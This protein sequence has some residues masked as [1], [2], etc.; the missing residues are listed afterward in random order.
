MHRTLRT[1]LAA[2]LVAVITL[3]AISITQD[4]G[5]SARIDCTAE[6]LYTLSDG[7]KAI[8]A[9][10]DR[11]IT[12][13]LYY[14]ATAAGKGPDWMK[15]LS[16][17]FH[18]VRD[19]LGEYEACA[20]GKIKLEV[21]DP[22]PYSD[23]EDQAIRHGLP[24]FPVNKDEAFYF[25]LVVRASFGKTETIPV[26]RGR[27]E[28]L[29]E[30]EITS[31]IEAAITRKRPRVGLLST[32]PVLGD[33]VTPQ[34]AQIMR[35]TQGRGPRLPWQFV[36]DLSRKYDVVEIAGDA[37]T[38]EENIDLLL[39]I[40]PKDLPE[41]TLFAIDQFVLGG[42]RMVACIDPLCFA[43]RPVRQPGTMTPPAH[44]PVSDLN[45]LL[46][47]WGV[48][49]ADK[50]V[51]GDRNLGLLVP[52]PGVSPQRY[53]R[54]VT[55]ME[56]GN[57]CMGPGSPISAGLSVMVLDCS[58][59]IEA[60]DLPNVETVPLIQTTDQGGTVAV[61][62][63]RMMRNAN[64]L[65]VS[66]VPADKPV[67]MGYLVKGRFR[68]AYP[69]GID[70][71]TLPSDGDPAGDGAPAGQPTMRKLTGL[72]VAETD[73]M[74]VV[75]ADV[76]FLT[77]RYY[78]FETTDGRARRN[79]TILFNAL[80][81]LGGSD[82][83]ISIRTRGR[84]RRSFTL[85]DKMEQ[86]ENNETRTERIHCEDQIAKIEKQHQEALASGNA[87][88]GALRTAAQLRAAAELKQQ[89]RALRQKIRLVRR[90]RQER[91]ESLGKRLQAINT[92]LV[93][94]CVLLLAI[95]LAVYHVLARRRFVGQLSRRPRG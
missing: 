68:S 75:L 50:S 19:L 85:V 80:D 48:S 90:R 3:A 1:I 30:Y 7:T 57:E 69:D 82:D 41:Q 46:P 94:A 35:M 39:V 5:R 27:G 52:V 40:H 26:F 38:I 60:V 63:P 53:T 24:G 15:Q 89:L 95:G 73:C 2:A 74:I 18:Y 93:P 62:D 70:V 4:L 88:N 32:L 29:V 33:D 37:E 45:P 59:A 54:N 72:K 14:S 55:W 20:D 8:L 36:N 49:M 58:G 91:V 13:K 47:A 79:G 87:A 11:P 16:D 31:R 81:V 12:I 56:L 34:M 43:D 86:R 71:Q 77:D 83:L 61:T 66:L 28:H 10:L 25:G 92:W 64:L 51:V 17:Y 22:R 23:A 42:G 76:D 84:F 67:V 65:N 9:K 21:I 6:K 78:Y 44:D